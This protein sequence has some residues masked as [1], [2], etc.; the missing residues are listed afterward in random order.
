MATPSRSTVTVIRMTGQRDQLRDYK[1]HLDGSERGTIAQGQ[2]IS[3]PVAP[4]S[5]QLQLTLD[6][7]KSKMVTVSVAE[8]HD[9][10]RYCRPSRGIVLALFKWRDY[11]DMQVEPWTDD[12]S[13][14]QKHSV[15]QFVLGVVGAAVID[16][17]AAIV[18]IGSLGASGKAVG[19]IGAL[20][21]VFWICICY[22]RDGFARH[23]PPGKGSD[24]HSDDPVEAPDRG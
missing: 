8:G 9:V 19:I 14:Y 13:S 4:G 16:F 23:S 7:A 15:R 21:A 22:W 18:L 12:P 24:I 20:L 5:H 2:C 3:V 17:V 6:W 11:I 1:V 10:V